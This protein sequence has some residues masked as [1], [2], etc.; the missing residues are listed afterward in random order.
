TIT[1]DSQQSATANG[2]RLYAALGALTPGRALAIGPGTWSISSRLDLSGTGSAQAPYFVIAANPAQ[3]PVITRP[4]A[5]QNA[6][7]VGSNAEARF[8]VLR[9]L[10]FTG[11]S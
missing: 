9:D 2:A 3:R 1:Y 4:D 5:N 11:G 7:N 8:W 6:V 10:E